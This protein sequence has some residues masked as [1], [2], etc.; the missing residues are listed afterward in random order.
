MTLL[1]VFDFVVV[2]V[3]IPI[4]DKLV[5]HSHTHENRRMRPCFREF[6]RFIKITIVFNDMK[7]KRLSVTT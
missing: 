1:D 7:L 4:D 2:G 5:E 6:N 3:V